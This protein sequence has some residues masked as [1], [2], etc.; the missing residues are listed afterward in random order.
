MENKNLNPSDAQGADE[1]IDLENYAQSG[2]KPPIGK[3]YRVKVD[4]EYF[5]FDHHLVTG[6]EILE[7]VGKIPVECH[8][9]Y[10]KFKHGDF[11]KIGLQD[12][13]DLLKPGIEHF[14]VKPP[15]VF[16]YTI[17]KEPET[18]DLHSLTPNQILEFAGLTPVSD[19]F[20]IQIHSDNT[21][22]SFKDQPNEPIKMKCPGLKFVSVS[23]RNTSVVKLLLWPKVILSW[24]SRLLD[25]NPK[26]PM[27]SR[28]YLN[29]R[30]QLDQ[31]LGNEY[32]WVLKFRMISQ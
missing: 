20:I 17:D 21:Q 6:K 13:V 30:S 31:I 11:E 15:E 24:S 1:I 16:Y 22:E 32:S 26:S 9:L 18:T 19:Y 4:N 2:K 8:S 5:I 23:R 7:K 29:M 12:K 28:L 10:Q 3:K 25:M 27:P 14:V